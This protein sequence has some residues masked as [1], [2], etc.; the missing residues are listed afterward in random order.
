MPGSPPGIFLPSF[1]SE[2][3]FSLT[4]PSGTVKMALGRAT[5]C[6]IP[7]VDSSPRGGYRF[8]E[9]RGANGPAAELLGN[10]LGARQHPHRVHAG[11]GRVL[12]LAELPRGGQE[13]P[14]HRRG[15]QGA[16]PATDA[17]LTLRLLFHLVPIGKDAALAPGSP[18]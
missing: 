5:D 16:G 15:P 12:H 6:R 1:W 7:A 13:R 17:G 3:R 8:R 10:P 18:V 4:F 2:A 9:R 14:P 11:A